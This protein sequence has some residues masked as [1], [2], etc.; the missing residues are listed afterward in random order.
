VPV[1]YK[2]EAQPFD[3][4]CSVFS[5]HVERD[6]LKSSTHVEDKNCKQTFSQKSV[7]LSVDGRI[8]LV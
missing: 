8:I 5:D 7:D 4:N 2:P 1:E 3:P 6:E